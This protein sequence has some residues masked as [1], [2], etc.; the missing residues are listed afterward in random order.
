MNTDDLFV[1]PRLHHRRWLSE[2]P[3]LCYLCLVRAVDVAVVVALVTLLVEIFRLGKTCHSL[4]DHSCVGCQQFLQCSNSVSES[5]S[6]GTME[7]KAIFKV[8][9]IFGFKYF[10]NELNTH[11]I[12]VDD[13][14]ILRIDRI[15]V[16]CANIYH[17]IKAGHPIQANE[18]MLGQYDHGFGVDSF[19]AIF[20]TL[21]D[22]LFAINNKNSFTICFFSHSLFQFL[23]D[24]WAN[25]HRRH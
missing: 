22:E 19:C 8:Y 7:W 18:T 15:D 13:M 12:I 11:R 9:E 23:P 16:K 2:Y 25:L 3:E 24:H 14:I 10:Q 20:T 4:L 5:V 17:F 21:I 1:D 6:I